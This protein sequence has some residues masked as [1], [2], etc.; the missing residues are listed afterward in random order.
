MDTTI[1]QTATRFNIDP[2]TARGVLEFFVATGL[3]S[4]AKAPKEANKRGRSKALY[5]L[6][7]DAMELLGKVHAVRAIPPTPKVGTGFAQ[8]ETVA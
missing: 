6:S 3:A 4:K 1:E 7:S 5:T 8:E 2:A